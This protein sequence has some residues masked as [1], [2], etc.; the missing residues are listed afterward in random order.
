ME[1]LGEEN[2]EGLLKFILLKNNK[3]M[4]NNSF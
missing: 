4:P 3:K 1:R 2:K